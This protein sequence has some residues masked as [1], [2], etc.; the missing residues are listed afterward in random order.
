VLALGP[1]PCLNPQQVFFFTQWNALQ[2][3]CHRRGISIRRANTAVGQR[4]MEN[5][6]GHATWIPPC[7][8]GHHVDILSRIRILATAHVSPLREATDSGRVRCHLARILRTDDQVIDEMV[9]ALGSSRRGSR[10]EQAIQNA[11]AASRPHAYLFSS[12]CV[13]QLDANVPLE[14]RWNAVKFCLGSL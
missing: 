10:I 2:W 9:A 6:D 13:G 14:M 3:N 7:S 4:A 8:K 11:V 5:S 12:S 1:S